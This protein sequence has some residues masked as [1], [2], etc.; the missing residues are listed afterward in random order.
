MEMNSIFPR[1]V[2]RTKQKRQKYRIK[3]KVSHV[4]C[5][6]YLKIFFGAAAAVFFLMILGRAGMSD[7]GAPLEQIFPCTFFYTIAFAACSLVV[8]QLDKLK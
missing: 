8:K 2:F 6:R 7:L 4:S 3:K 1:M 5:V